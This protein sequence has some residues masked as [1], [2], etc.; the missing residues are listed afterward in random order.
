M[1]NENQLK[2]TKAEKLIILMLCDIQK[3]LKIDSG[4]KPEI[5]EEA[6]MS[7]NTWVF[8]ERLNQGDTPEISDEQL[9]L[10]YDILDMYSYL[11]VSFRD[12]QHADDIPQDQRSSI[13]KAVKFP[14]FDGN[15]ESSY[16]SISRMMKKMALYECVDGL[17][18]NSHRRM[19]PTYQKMLVI[20][21]KEIESLSN[22]ECLTLESIKK[23]ISSTI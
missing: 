5:I 15:N 10:V 23:I 3:E 6:I 8:E 1:S 22:G 17:I 21:E 2:L 18:N 12:L 9:T 20:H 19:L 16:L 13:E 11:Q 4:I 7:G 14:G